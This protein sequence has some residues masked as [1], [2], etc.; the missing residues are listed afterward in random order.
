[1][2]RIASRRAAEWTIAV[3]ILVGCAAGTC[4]LLHGAAAP[5]K[6]SSLADDGRI[7]K[8]ADAQG[9]VLLRPAFAQRWTPV[10]PGTLVTPGD[11]LRTDV[12]GANALKV[13]LSSDVE[14]TLGPG[15]L[16]ECI[17]PTQ[18]RLHAGELQVRLLEAAKGGEINE[19]GEKAAVARATS[20]ELLGPREGSQR[21]SGSGKHLVSV[22]ESEKIVR[23]AK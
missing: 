15:S 13:L 12:R 21:F 19:R 16:V 11:W 1:M 3:A 14:L 7:G 23:V 9:L 10:C 4:G 18:A 22:D 5:E 8:I 17:T 6:S 2:L 20:F